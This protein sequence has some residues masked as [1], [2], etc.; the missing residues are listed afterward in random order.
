LQLLLRSSDK[1]LCEKRCRIIGIDPNSDNIVCVEAALEALPTGAPCVARGTLRR[2][3][4]NRLGCRARKVTP[5]SLAARKAAR[6]LNPS[7]QRGEALVVSSLSIGALDQ[8]IGRVKQRA[9][10]ARWSKEIAPAVARLSSVSRKTTSVA[11][12]AAY[13]AA[14]AEVEEDL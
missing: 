8:A 13:H 9:C 11:H 1:T 6:V 5:V 2:N 3:E 7:S 10:I 12:L 14:S 4:G